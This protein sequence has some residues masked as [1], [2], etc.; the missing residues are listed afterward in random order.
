MND[1]AS[2]GI[3]A[4]FTVFSRIGTCLIFMPGLSSPRIPVQARLFI[5]IALSLAITPLIYDVLRPA[6]VGVSPAG[7]LKLMGSELLIGALI[8]L[9][10]RVFFVG[11]ETLGVALSF[12]IG[13]TSNLRS[14]DQRRRAVAGD[15]DATD[16]ECDGADVRDRPSI[17]KSSRHS[18]PPMATCRS[19]AAMR[20]KPDWCSS[21]T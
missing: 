12:S 4:A 21:S 1:L 2:T 19:A 13:L 15:H 18:P 3:L 7:L 9:M 10:G 11:L 5:A 14:S 16:P 17:S 6:L 20:P 8:G